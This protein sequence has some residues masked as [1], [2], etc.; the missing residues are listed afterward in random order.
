MNKEK[1]FS[2][3]LRLHF[4]NKKFHA[5]YN[6][7][8]FINNIFDIEKIQRV[9]HNCYGPL[10][11]LCWDNPQEGLE[12]GSWVS[13]ADNV[14]FI[15]GGNHELGHL[16]TY[17]LCFDFTDIKKEVPI[18]N[19]TNGKI[20]IGDDVWI[21]SGAVILSGVNIGQG[22]VVGAG[23]VVT[24]DVPAYAIVGGNPAQV[25]RYRFS[26]K[27]IDKL[28]QCS[29]EKIDYEFIKKNYN[30]FGKTISDDTSDILNI[31]PLK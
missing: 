25:I 22:A 14:R 3:R 28:L 30:I 17:P 31:L 20:V 1:Y 8:L 4:I 9:G 10:N 5:K 26:D 23:S 18:N 13:I 27:V 7:K 6:T 16:L 21:G 12:I 24:K 2:E 19:L 29:L 11:V 15:L